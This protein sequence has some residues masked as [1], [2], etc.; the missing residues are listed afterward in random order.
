MR[1]IGIPTI[2][3]YDVLVGLITKKGKNIIYF[4]SC[5]RQKPKSIRK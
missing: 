5:L 3:K 2:E 4:K 1:F